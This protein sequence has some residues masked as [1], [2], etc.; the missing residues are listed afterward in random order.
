M[1][2]N[3]VDITGKKFNM[4]TVICREGKKGRDLLWRCR[5]DCG[6]EIVV[7]GGN[8]KKG[9]PKSCGCLNSK[10]GKKFGR[11]LVV[12]IK[13]KDDNGYIWSC[14]CDCGNVVNRTTEYLTKQKEKASCGCHWSEKCVK[15]GKTGIRLF[16]V[17]MSLIARC[18]DKKNKAYKNYGG[19]GIT[20]CDEW[21][22]FQS[23]YD[24]SYA[25]G[26]DENAQ[27]GKCTI[28][29]IDN[30]GNYC[31]DN[32]RWVTM[33][34]QSNNK[35]NNI[36]VEI[37]GVKKT[38][39]EWADFSGISRSTIKQRYHKGLNDERLISPVKKGRTKI[40]NND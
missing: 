32:C 18:Y 27:T 20:I 35:R 28:D 38:L 21:R 11:L 10:I 31:P 17:W 16:G 8:L 23:F 5:C 40:E 6:N 13:T 39:A 19:R 29:R 36:F 2:N 9:T 1:A 30:N 25:N 26:Y 7:G 4:L 33:K 12:G 15:H 3:I 34:K 24:W 37:N 14:K 22:D